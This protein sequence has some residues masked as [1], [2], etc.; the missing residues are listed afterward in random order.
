[1]RRE[2]D[3]RF[4][5]LVGRLRRAVRIDPPCPRRGGGRRGARPAGSGRLGGA[6]R[7]GRGAG[8]GRGHPRIGRHAGW[9]GW[10][11]LGWSASGDRGNGARSRRQCVYGRLLCVRRASSVG[12]GGYRCGPRDGRP[13]R[14][15]R[16]AVDR[17]SSKHRRSRHRRGAGHG[18][19]GRLRPQR[20]AAGE[21]LRWGLRVVGHDARLSVDLVLTMPGSVRK[22][23]RDV[24]PDERL[25]FVRLPLGL[26]PRGVGFADV[27]SVK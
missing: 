25:L 5:V 3:D 9:L 4:G 7:S 23:F 2:K 6:L 8:R 1:M 21:D 19:G 27:H 13:G 26:P 20:L 12:S 11:L 17:R 10:G 16:G 14:N 24:Q 15:G 22:R 18:R